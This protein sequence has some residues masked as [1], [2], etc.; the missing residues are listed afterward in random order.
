MLRLIDGLP[1]DTLGVSAAGIV[2]PREYEDIFLAALR[3]MPRGA[4]LLF[5]AGP[6]FREF[7]PK[8]WPET[9]LLACDIE[10]IALVTNLAWLRQAAG[11]CAPLLTGELAVFAPADLPSAV[12][13]LAD[14]HAHGHRSFI[15]TEILAP[16]FKDI[17]A[18][19]DAEDRR[20]DNGIAKRQR[21]LRRKLRK[22]AIIP[23]NGPRPNGR[24]VQ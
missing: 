20:H 1:P 13:W 2:T 7:A 23:D 21:R 24:H 11:I 8:G 4:R 18:I 12:E 10:R 22:T 19:V 5:I 3:E 16:S 9:G 14:G 15:D 6:S 17:G